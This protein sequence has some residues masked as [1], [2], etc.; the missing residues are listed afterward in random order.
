MSRMTLSQSKPTFFDAE[1][2]RR[3]LYPKVTNNLQSP[4][5]DP[6]IPLCQYAIRDDEQ[7][8]KIHIILPN[9]SCKKP[10][11]IVEGGLLH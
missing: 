8:Y 3:M 9:L 2:R 5:K 6:R 1:M 11:K 7:A 10:F 4:T